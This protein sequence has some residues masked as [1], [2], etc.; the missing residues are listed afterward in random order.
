[1]S[2]LRE[3][4]LQEEVNPIEIDP[5]ADRHVQDW[6]NRHKP[7]Y[8]QPGPVE[9]VLHE[10]LKWVIVELMGHVRIAG[11][12]ESIKDLGVEFMRV[13]VIDEEG[14]FICTQDIGGA[15]IYRRTFCDY[16]SAVAVDRSGSSLPPIRWQAEERW[17]E[18]E[19]KR[20]NETA[21]ATGMDEPEDD[22][23]PY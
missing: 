6:V 21:D 19:R 23:L 1:M 20:R 9:P 3:T 22:Y 11:A 15:A 5:V 10:A 4:D 16:A 18:S 2:H 12:Y 13:H 14:K 8:A 17:R 7:T